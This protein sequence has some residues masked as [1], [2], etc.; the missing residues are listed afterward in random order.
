MSGIEDII[1]GLSGMITR[2]QA[3]A[4]LDKSEASRK[5]SAADPESWKG[6]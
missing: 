6:S 2:E 5:T 3:K 4:L 1:D